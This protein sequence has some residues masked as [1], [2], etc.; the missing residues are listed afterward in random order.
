MP[1]PTTTQSPISMANDWMYFTIAGINS[2][3]SIPHDGIKGFK[4]ETG[5]DVKKGKGTVGATLTL[6]DRPP[7][8]GTIELDLITSADFA[9]YDALIAQVLAVD[10]KA[11]QQTGFGI[12]HPAFTSIGLTQVVVAYYTPPLPS[13]TKR[14]YRVTIGFIEWQPP[15]PVSVVSTVA[16]AA[17]DGSS[18]GPKAPSPARQ[19]LQQQLKVAQFQKR[20]AGL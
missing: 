8:K 1:A 3:G 6:K 11:Q 13:G 2:P 18:K 9:G 5:W 17:P 10:A 19:A 4:R 12:Y 15:P 14:K 20:A 16:S 7:C